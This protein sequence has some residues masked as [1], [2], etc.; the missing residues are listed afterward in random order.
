MRNGGVRSSQSCCERAFVTN[1]SGYAAS[2]LEAQRAI[3]EK[4]EA[5]RTKIIGKLVFILTI[6]RGL[7]CATFKQG[8]KTRIMR[9]YRLSLL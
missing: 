1:V 3:G 2:F 7:K 8:M 9:H 4:N 6:I 5:A